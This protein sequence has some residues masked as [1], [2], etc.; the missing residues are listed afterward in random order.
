MDDSSIQP[1]FHTTRFLESLSIDQCLFQTYAEPKGARDDRALSRTMIGTF[2]EH[3]RTLQRINERGAAVCAMINEGNGSKQRSNANVTAVRSVFVDLDGAPLEPILSAPLSPHAIVESS[4]KKFH[5][6]WSVR[7]CPVDEFKSVQLK[8]ADRFGGDRSVNDLARV[9]R[10]PG[11]MHLKSQP[12]RSRVVACH[13]SPPYRFAELLEALSF[14]APIADR[15]Q[16]RIT[17][18]ARN[19]TIYGMAR[20]LRK[21]GIAVDE[22]HRRIDLVNMSRCEPPLAETE[23]QR[24]VTSAYS[25]E[26]E[27]DIA[28]PCALFESPAYLALSPRARNLAIHCYQ[29]VGLTGRVDIVLAHS[30]FAAQFPKSATFHRAR[31]E[32]IQ[33]GLVIETKAAKRPTPKTGPTPAHFKLLYLPSK[34]KPV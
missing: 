28:V 15:N 31:D 24:T 30:N 26:L 14:D 9:M 25:H 2:G 4:P 32:L 19:K 12:F 17:A 34:V 5:A 1:M 29:Q 6:Y 33:A 11:F 21:Q 7:E 16:S 27:I 20:G 18:G 13:S 8:L 10:L 3:F 23:V 22:A